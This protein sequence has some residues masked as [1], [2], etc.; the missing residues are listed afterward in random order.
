MK[1]VTDA[2]RA[3]HTLLVKAASLAEAVVDEH[4]RLRPG[5]MRRY[6][7]RGRRYCV[8]DTRF[9]LEF[10]AASV[11]IGDSR[12]FVRYVVWVNGILTAR[13]IPTGDLVEA[14][15]VMR[16]VLASTLPADASALVCPHLDAALGALGQPN[17][18]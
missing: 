8:E 17:P 9:H 7:R 12:H 14:L 3:R 13:G 4:Y 1:L 18:T 6:G 16:Q 2:A 5:P 11:G 15:G 10:L